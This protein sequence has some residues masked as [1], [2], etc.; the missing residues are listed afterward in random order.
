MHFCIKKIDKGTNILISIKYNL[1]DKEA[2]YYDS[3]EF[4]YYELNFF[5]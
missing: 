1:G 2:N 5:N 3:I 4:D